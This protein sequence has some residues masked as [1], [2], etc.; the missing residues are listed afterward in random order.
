MS[1]ANS[2][3]KKKL[4]IILSS[5]IICLMILILTVI[6]LLLLGKQ[7]RSVASVEKVTD[8]LYQMTYYGDYKL[9]EMCTA[10]VSTVQELESWLSKNIFWG[11]PISGNETYYGCSAFLAESPDGDYLLGRNYDYDKTETL[12]LYTEPEDGYASYALADLDMLGVGGENDMTGESLMGRISML[13]SPYTITEGMNEAGLGVAILEL[14]TEEIHQDNGKYDMLLCVAVRMILD[15][16]ANV[17]EAVLLLQEY[18][19][20][21]FFGYPYHLFISDSTGRSVVVEWIDGQ[22]EV[23]DADYVTN[24]QLSEGE[25]YLYGIGHDRYQIMENKFSET[26]GILTSEESMELLAEVQVPWNGEWDTEWSCVMNLTDF[27]VEVCIDQMYDKVYY[28]SR[29]SFLK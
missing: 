7:I 15:K 23:I 8:G 1:H 16:T 3:R 28:F 21:S 17:E 11:Y 12:I 14:E 26:N 9:D 4:L 2:K 19:I 20:H 6:L 24:F 25:D 10:N 5:V 22:M 13:A 18:D 29:E 27:T